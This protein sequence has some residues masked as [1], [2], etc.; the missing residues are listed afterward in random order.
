MELKCAKNYETD[1]HAIELT[2]E[3]TLTGK[4]TV[5]MAGP[6]AIESRDQILASAEF[7]SQL[8]VKILRG[9]AFKP[10]TNPYSFQGS[11]EEGLSWMAEARDRYGMTLIT[12]VTDMANFDIVAKYSDI[13][14]IGAKAMYNH[15]VLKA[16][17]KTIKPILLKRHFGATVDELMK[18]ADYIILNGNAN[19]MFCERGIRT[20]ESSSRF[21]LDLCG[22]AVMQERSR[23]PLI[24]DPSHAI[25]YS[26]G[27]P[28][29]AKAAIAFGCDGVI[30]EVHP[31]RQ[32]AQCDKDQALS[33]EEF[34][35]LYSQLRDIAQAVGRELV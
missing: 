5:V 32:Y 12:E 34:K 10:R 13:I 24:L 35:L 9:G 20:F 7:M 3:I 17:G 27:V 18:M 4:E 29:L 33:H 1:F 16:A 31:D 26:F 21:T 6:C 2:K 14:Q 11:G 22:A 25:G 28:K 15:S 19:V 30:I 8:G 23:Q